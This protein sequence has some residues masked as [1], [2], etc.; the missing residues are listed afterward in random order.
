MGITGVKGT[1]AGLGLGSGHWPVPDIE[2]VP[3]GREEALG[4][5][6]MRSG[7]ANGGGGKTESS[8]FSFSP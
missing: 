4:A 2:N 3:G 1:E 7:W 6:P 8:R 5:A